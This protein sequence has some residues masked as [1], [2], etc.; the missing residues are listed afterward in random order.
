MELIKKI[1]WLKSSVP[2]QI[3]FGTDV[4]DW[5]FT[6]LVQGCRHP[7]CFWDPPEQFPGLETVSGN[8]VALTCHA[9]EGSVWL[10]NADDGK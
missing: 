2:C 10:V 5:S 7:D 4:V 6:E 3:T 1:P 8:Q 9:A